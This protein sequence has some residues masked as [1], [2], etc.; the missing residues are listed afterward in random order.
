MLR[1]NIREFS[2]KVSTNVK[3]SLLSRL[4][5]IEMQYLSDVLT[6]LK[7]ETLSKYL[8]YFVDMHNFSLI[9]THCDAYKSV[10]SLFQR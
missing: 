3:V 4:L 1:V 9:I 10:I 6:K 2:R 8:F 7:I 5:K